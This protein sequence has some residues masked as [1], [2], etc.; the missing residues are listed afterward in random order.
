MLQV[1]F[2]LE[3]ARSLVEKQYW[4]KCSFVF[5]NNYLKSSRCLPQ[6]RSHISLS[7]WSVNSSSENLLDLIML[8]LTIASSQ[9]VLVAETK[10]RSQKK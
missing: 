6:Y 1:D 3:Y 7:S 2:S 4:S 10:T 9:Y 8:H 5:T